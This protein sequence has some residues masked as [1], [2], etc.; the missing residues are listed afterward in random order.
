MRENKNNNSKQIKAT[1]NIHD[2][3]EQ[4]IKREKKDRHAHSG[5][6]FGAGLKKKLV[7]FNCFFNSE[8]AKRTKPKKKQINTQKHV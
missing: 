1:K 2:Q 3:N 4:K 8:W 7:A 6:I 5:T